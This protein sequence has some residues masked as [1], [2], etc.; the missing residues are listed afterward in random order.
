MI[1]LYAIGALYVAGIGYW[2]RA[3]LNYLIMAVYARLINWR[4]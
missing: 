3:T 4:H 1:W 2:K